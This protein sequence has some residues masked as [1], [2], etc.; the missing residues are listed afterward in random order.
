MAP[1]IGVPFN[2]HWYPEILPLPAV[3]V[4]V[5]KMLPVQVVVAPEILT[6]GFA[7]TVTEI[8]FEVAL[9]PLA[10]VVTTW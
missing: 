10:S 2:D 8:V 1:P 5:S 7:L 6:V 3:A 4:A 9:Q